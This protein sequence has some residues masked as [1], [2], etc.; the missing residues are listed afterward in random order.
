MTQDLP[1]DEAAPDRAAEP[2]SRRRSRT[3]A[4]SWGPAANGRATREPQPEIAALQGRAARLRSAAPASAASGSRSCC[5][6][7]LLVLT[8]LTV[9]WAWP[10]WISA[11]LLIVTLVLLLFAGQTVI[12]LLRL[13]AADRRTRR[14]PTGRDG[15][16]DRRHDR[17]RGG[18][19]AE[20]TRDAA[21]G[22]DKT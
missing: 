2:T 22:D 19:H 4:G 11:T 13:V 18:G 3:H 21:A 7:I 16:Q 20:E 14:R 10:T 17:G 1:L 9:V 12:F 8:P 15:A 6:G 5:S